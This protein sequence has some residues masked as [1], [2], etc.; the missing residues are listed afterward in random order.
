MAALFPRRNVSMVVQGQCLPLHCFTGIKM[1]FLK[2]DLCYSRPLAIDIFTTRSIHLVHCETLAVCKYFCSVVLILIMWRTH[3]IARFMSINM[4][5]IFAAHTVNADHWG[6]K[7]D[8]YQKSGCEDRFCAEWRQDHP[9]KDQP[10]RA[11]QHCCTILSR[12]CPRLGM[13]LCQR[14][15]PGTILP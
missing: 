1:E 14:L 11:L 6:S 8:S 7:L 15:R 9:E 2:F 5:S 12:R 13:C 4:N 10:R 3:H